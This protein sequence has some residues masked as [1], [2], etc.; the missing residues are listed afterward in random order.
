MTKNNKKAF[1]VTQT[2]KHMTYLTNILIQALSKIDIKTGNLTEGINF[3]D[4]NKKL[5]END[6]RFIIFSIGVNIGIGMGNS[7]DQQ[8][9]YR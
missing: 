4:E 1:G 7:Q 9:H 8:N 6:K 2:K 5:T 3:L